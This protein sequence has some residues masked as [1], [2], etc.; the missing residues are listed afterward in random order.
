MDRCFLG[1]KFLGN[2][3]EGC[4]PYLL[5]FPKVRLSKESDCV[6]PVYKG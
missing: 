5:K 3:S 6:R 1:K 2:E 4:K